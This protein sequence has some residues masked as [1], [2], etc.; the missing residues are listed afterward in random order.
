M[1]SFERFSVVLPRAA[2][3]R[4][5]PRRRASLAYRPTLE[6][7]EERTV[8]TGG[9]PITTLGAATILGSILPPTNQDGGQNGQGV[10]Y[11]ANYET[12]YAALPNVTDDFTASGL[13]IPSSDWWSSVIFRTVGG[14]SGYSANAAYE[15]TDGTSTYTNVTVNNLSYPLFA[16]PLIL[17]VDSASTVSGPTTTYNPRG[18]AIGYAGTFV[19][20]GVNAPGQNTDAIVSASFNQDLLVGLVDSTSAPISSAHIAVDNYSDWGATFAWSNGQTGSQA[21]S[22]TATSANGS[23]Y[24]FFT[25]AGGTEVRVSLSGQSAGPSLAYLSTNG[26]VAVV[27]VPNGAGGAVS[28]N[29]VY[30]LFSPA[31]GAW[32]YSEANGSTPA[33]LTMSLTGVNATASYFSIAVLPSSVVSQTI[34]ANNVLLETFRQHAYAFLLGPA[35]TRDGGFATTPGTQLVDTQYDSTTSSVT[36]ILGITTRLMD[37]SDATLVNGALTAL[38]AHQF[39]NLGSTGNIDPLFDPSGLQ[40]TYNSGKGTMRLFGATGAGQAHQ[41]QSTTFSTKMH[42]KGILPYLPNALTSA[43]AATRDRLIQY[44]HDVATGLADTKGLPFPGISEN[45]NFISI[46]TNY[47]AG[48][49]MLRVGLVLPIIDQLLSI[50]T[51]QTKIAQLTED[52]T[53][54]LAQVQS[55]MA[56]FFDVA[57]HQ[58]LAYN[59]EWDTLIPYPDDN[60]TATNLNDKHF[61]WGYFLRAAALIARYNP[62]FISPMNYGPILNLIARDAGNWERTPSGQFPLPFLR[63]FN[64]YAGHSWANG[65]A[66]GGNGNN[67]ESSAEAINFAVG[68][69][70]F[71]D[72]YSTFDAVMGQTIRDWGIYLFTTETE[73]IEQYYFNV[74]QDNYPDNFTL[75]YATVQTQSSVTATGTQVTLAGSSIPAGFPQ[76][77]NDVYRVRLDNETMLVT[78]RAGNVLDVIRGYDGSIAAAHAANVGVSLL[79][80]FTTL[81]QAIGASDASLT[82]TSI[83]GFPPAPANG[84]TAIQFKIRIDAEILTVTGGAGTTTWT[85]LRGQD[86]TTAQSHASGASAILHGQVAPW[87]N[88]S[89]PVAP[90]DSTISIASSATLGAFPDPSLAPFQID[91]GPERMLVTGQVNAT[92]WSVLRGFAG[93]HAVPHATGARFQLVTRDFSWSP[94]QTTVTTTIDAQA[95]SIVVDE[96][97]STFGGFDGIPNV[98]TTTAISGQL[99]S[100]STTLAQPITDTV[101]AVIN[102][103]VNDSSPSITAGQFFITVG[104]GGNESYYFVQDVL[105]AP[106]TTWNVKRLGSS[107]YPTYSAGETVNVVW[108]SGASISDLT[109]HPTLILDASTLP[110]IA[111]ALAPFTVSVGSDTYTVNAILG[112]ANNVWQI[113]APLTNTY[114]AGT[115]VHSAVSSNSTVIAVTSTAGFPTAGAFRILVDNEVML[116]QGSYFD[117]QTNQYL[118][119]LWNVQRGYDGTQAAAHSNSSGVAIHWIDPET[120]FTVQVEEER[121]RVLGRSAPDTWTVLR[122]ADGTTPSSHNSGAFV[123]LAGIAP[124]TRVDITGR[125]FGSGPQKTTFF[126]TPALDRE[127]AFR[128]IQS[129]PITGASLY[130][131]QYRNADGTSTV[132]SEAR[133]LADFEQFLINAQVYPGQVNGGGL[134]PGTI[135]GYQALADAA[136][137]LGNFDDFLTDNYAYNVLVGTLA[138]ESVS[139]GADGVLVAPS[140]GVFIIPPDHNPILV[141]FKVAFGDSSSSD[142]LLLRQ[143]QLAADGYGNTQFTGNRSN[144][145]DQPLGQKVVPVEFTPAEIGTVTTVGSLAWGTSTVTVTDG[146][147]NPFPFQTPIGTPENVRF[148]VQVP[149]LVNGQTVTETWQVNEQTRNADNTRTWSVT[150]QLVPLSTAVNLAAPSIAAGTAITP[151]SS[152]LKI[153]AN[154]GLDEGESAANTYNFINQL[155]KL[156][157]PDPNVVAVGATQYAVFRDANAHRS[158]AV[159]NNS[160]AALPS[161]A[162][163]AMEPDGT[164]SGT[165]MHTFTNVAPRSFVWYS[166]AT[167]LTTTEAIPS[168]TTPTTANQF[169]LLNTRGNNPDNLANGMSSGAD[170]NPG[171]DRT[172]LL[173]LPTTGTGDA[174]FAGGVS[175][176]IHNVSGT[177]DSTQSNTRFRLFTVSGSTE[178]YS[179]TQPSL[180]ETLTA[181]LP[182]GAAYSTVVRVSYYSTSDTGPTAQP[183]R[184]ELFQPSTH[185]NPSDSSATNTFDEYTDAV[186]LQSSSGSFVDMTGGSVKVEVW[187]WSINS[188]GAQ[189]VG[190]KVSTPVELDPK[191]S[192]I[193][194]PYSNV[195]TTGPGIFGTIA[196]QPIADH[197]LTRPFATVT[198]TNPSAPTGSIQAVVDVLDSRHGFFTAR[199]L[200][201]SGFRRSNVGQSSSS[202]R[203]LTTTSVPYTFSGTA[204]Q[205]T[206]ALRQLIFQPVRSLGPVGSAR[207]IPLRITISQDGGVSVTD[208]TTSLHARNAAPNNASFI[209]SLYVDLLGRN[210]KPSE[211]SRWSQRLARGATRSSVVQTL[212][213]TREH[214]VFQVEGY[215]ADFLGRHPGPAATG[216][217]GRRLQNGL[218]EEALISRLLSS[219]EFRERFSNNS[220]YIDAL[221]REL[222]GR[223][224][225]AGDRVRGLIELRRGV[226]PA[227]YIESLLSTSQFRQREIRR[228]SQTWLGGQPSPAERAQYLLRFAQSP[229]GIAAAF[230]A[231]LASAT[232][233]RRS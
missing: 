47:P 160:A 150:R 98:V 12:P 109:D 175:F 167:G 21:A 72:A 147:G 18:V 5:S 58:W 79:D 110:T 85:V 227:A 38:Y 128:V 42:Y 152:F 13:P 177:Y 170:A 218:R 26:R 25:T 140:N 117:T 29:N 89:S 51:D 1:G 159:Y 214:R 95:N 102:I 74:D 113:S 66:V 69:I 226:Q 71:G 199:S 216:L 207:V 143:M 122:G 215:F 48:K 208:E 81:R 203:E 22:I 217:W 149:V 202:V 17:Q 222:L 184:V 189:N 196:L 52:R 200:A 41:T 164:L 23:P 86:G 162:F 87:G 156:G 6:S 105:S 24:V 157:Q 103:T 99:L 181:A 126:A 30:A 135:W 188:S 165:A 50:T 11:G 80:P 198:V 83:A 59:E 195:S 212:W 176:V 146:V 173:T 10:P 19:N 219:R 166:E 56:E 153:N 3:K 161:V 141:Y 91:F 68:L 155:V 93:T 197:W 73:A 148:W 46:D 4:K 131:G 62:D 77:A 228:L 100:F 75:N 63:N 94:P 43:D 120:A 35:A 16:D 9:S 64:P 190:L 104:T 136:F 36:T 168:L 158:Y 76:G 225:T 232:Y 49:H 34:D 233:Y 142:T 211:L 112:E 53:A 185:N 108:P 163:Y 229:Y 88:L 15:L 139:A 40:Y 96:A 129:L 230:Q 130:L 97:S 180:L 183:F 132:Q 137:A 70:Q 193:L 133:M 123:S 154:S 14:G 187:L 151:I 106:H 179:P 172:N 221:Y 121:M 125:L 171:G 209:Q 57:G 134:Y 144:G 182:T 204:A 127:A 55:A 44:V 67:Q 206:T 31:G 194:I 191:A 27:V 220:Q 118:P 90:T 82:V 138:A 174:T 116:V 119:N 84:A 124:I 7:L 145:V 37:T 205:V 115:D 54:L 201:A 33:T 213:S 178:S 169:F 101:D 78:S 192:Q 107:P 28:S 186:G 32:A 114:S 231:I 111:S 60:G 223:P 92:T 8:L 61:K 224:S 65:D 45:V 39:K 2:N 20:T 210:A